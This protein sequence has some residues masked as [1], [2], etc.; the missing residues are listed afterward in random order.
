MRCTYLQL[1]SPAMCVYVCV[2]L[3]AHTCVWLWV[4][5]C[6]WL[7]VH[8]CVCRQT[9]HYTGYLCPPIPINHS[10]PLT[11]IWQHMMIACEGCRQPW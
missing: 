8:T 2:W 10:S 1:G 11:W 6:V 4:H 5:T 7:W 9:A 3:W